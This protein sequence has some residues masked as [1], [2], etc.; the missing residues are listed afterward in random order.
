MRVRVPP[1]AYGD[2]QVEVL[3]SPVAEAWFMAKNVLEATRMA[4]AVARD[5]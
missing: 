1:P 4:F 2:L 5:I 3:W